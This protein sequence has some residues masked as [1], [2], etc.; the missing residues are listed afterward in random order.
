[1][2]NARSFCYIDQSTNDV[3][4][5]NNEKYIY[6]KLLAQF[7]TQKIDSKHPVHIRLNDFLNF[8]PESLGDQL[9]CL[10]LYN[11]QSQNMPPNEIVFS[12]TSQKHEFIFI[13]CMISGGKRNSWKFQ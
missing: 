2:H 9:F 6:H 5:G 7:F 12:F 4:L 3:S 8:S 1:M 10:Y 13:D 11:I